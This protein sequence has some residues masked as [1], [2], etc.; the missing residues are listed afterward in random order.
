MYVIY[1]LLF[2]FFY[3][4]KYFF[5]CQFVNL[6]VPNKTI[7]EK[8]IYWIILLLICIDY[9]IFIPLT[10]RLGHLHKLNRYLDFQ[11]QYLDQFKKHQ[12]QLN[13]FPPTIQMVLH[14]L[15]LITISITH[16]IFTPFN[17]PKKQ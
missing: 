7:I 4:K 15:Q 8:N 13:H 16:R 14:N 17:V 6:F 1:E 10:L 2:F 5:V 12:D 3:K 11:T 9:L